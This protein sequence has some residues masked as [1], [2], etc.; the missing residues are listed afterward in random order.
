[1]EKYKKFS[2]NKVL[3]IFL[4]LAITFSV[5]TVVLGVQANPG[6]DLSTIGG[7]AVG[8]ILYGSAT[9]VV[10]SLAD[11]AVG[12]YLRSGGVGV[13]PLWSTITLPNA[14]TTGDLLYGS[15]SKKL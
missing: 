5:V 15:A 9:D 10:S 12:S 4:L 7:A 6:H 3:S 1:M 8:G 11:V 14:V 13:A 2:R